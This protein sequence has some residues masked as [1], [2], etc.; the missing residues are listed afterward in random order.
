ML[1]G[2]LLWPAAIAR[3]LWHRRWRR[4][5]SLTGMPIVAIGLLIGLLRAGFDATWVRLQFRK[6]DLLT[7]I[8]R[9]PSG[10][11]RLA[12]WHWGH[13]GLTAFDVTASWIVY[14]ESDRLDPGEMQN[15]E[16]WRQRTLAA[17]GAY[18]PDETDLW[19]RKVDGHFY[20]VQLAQY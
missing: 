5:I 3:Q 20:L 6:Q 17:I 12:A 4:F 1:I 9:L 19:A 2:T 18:A 8:A 16:A 14:D 7:D 10:L 11:P 15:S 13:D